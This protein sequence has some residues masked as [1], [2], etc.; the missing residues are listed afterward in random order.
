MDS[1]KK[2]MNEAINEKINTGDYAVKGDIGL[3]PFSQA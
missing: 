2:M 3:A 1:L